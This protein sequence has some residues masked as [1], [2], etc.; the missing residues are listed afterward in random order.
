MYSVDL[1]DLRETIEPDMVES[2]PHYQ[3][4]VECFDAIRSA[5]GDGVVPY[6]R[7]QIMKYTWRMG[8]KGPALEDARKASWYM[9]RLVEELEA[10]G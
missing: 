3:G 9:A 2:P 10:R 4:K 6:L 8:S 7:G 1:K 5:L